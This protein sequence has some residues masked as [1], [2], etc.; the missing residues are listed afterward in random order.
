MQITEND[1]AADEVF[2]LRLTSSLRK[3]AEE[4]SQKD[5][6]DLNQ[7]I[8]LAVEH[9]LAQVQHDKWVEG[10]SKPT[11]EYMAAALAILDR[12]NGNEPDPGDELP[13]GYVSI[14]FSPEYKKSAGTE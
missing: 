3:Q 7:F 10:R 5:G 13:E 14:R 4:L 9:A 11:P 8:N 1:P 6:V 2:P 12:D